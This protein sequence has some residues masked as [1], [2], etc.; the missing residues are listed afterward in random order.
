MRISDES[1]FTLANLFYGL[2]ALV[3]LFILGAIFIYLIRGAL[4]ADVDS[5]KTIRYPTIINNGS[6]GIVTV[7]I[8]FDRKARKRQAVTV[9]LWEDDGVWG[10]DLLGE[11]QVT[12]LQGKSSVVVNFTL[13][14]SADGEL[15]G[16]NDDG[17]HVYEVYGYV[18]DD[19]NGNSETENKNNEVKCVSPIE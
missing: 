6:N 3:V 9:Q 15:N 1:G 7:Q 17:D 2:A 10:D 8:D 19:G 4:S 16:D 13:N 11:K 5:V 12:L 14:C 18:K